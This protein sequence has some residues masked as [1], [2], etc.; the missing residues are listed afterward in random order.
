MDHPNGSLN[1]FES[2][3]YCNS[4]GGTLATLEDAKFIAKMK[5]TNVP[6]YFWFDKKTEGS[7]TFFEL[8][9]DV[10]KEK[11]K[12]LFDLSCYANLEYICEIPKNAHISDTTGFRKSFNS[13]NILLN[14]FKKFNFKIKALSFT[15]TQC[16][17]M[18]PKWIEF[19]GKCYYISTRKLNY[20]NAED[21]CTNK[22]GSVVS[23]QTD[24]SKFL[25]SAVNFY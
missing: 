13:K 24:N 22:G 25:V 17:G 12:N 1:W 15:V 14:N 16:L 18:S 7:C 8:E 20:K 10:T 19:Q 2:K 9:N 11:K 21:Y 6:R 23:F 4:I 3:S 5:K